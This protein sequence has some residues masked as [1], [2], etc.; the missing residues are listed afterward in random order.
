MVEGPMSTN[1]HP[2]GWP[3]RTRLTPE[4]IALF[5][6]LEV[7]PPRRRNAQ[8]WK[9]RERKLMSALGLVDEFWTM[10]SVLNRNGPCHPPYYIANQHHARCREVRAALLAAAGLPGANRAK[11]KTANAALRT[12]IN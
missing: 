11:R 2:R 5:A 10:N 4:L 12:A 9:D 7:T 8:S 1:R 6:E 3:L